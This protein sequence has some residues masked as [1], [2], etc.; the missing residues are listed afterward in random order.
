M[1]D[2]ALLRLLADVNHFLSET[3]A[4]E[5]LSAAAEE[6][7]E[8]LIREIT[9]HLSPPA[10]PMT[11]PPYLDMNGGSRSGG[12][13]VEEYVDSDATG[14]LEETACYE[15]FPSEVDGGGGGGDCGRVSGPLVRWERRFLLGHA[16]RCWASLA[17]GRLLLYPGRGAASAKPSLALCLRGYRARPACSSLVRASRKRDTHFEI[18][19]PGKKTYQ[20]I[21]PSAKEMEQWVTAICL[22]GEQEQSSVSPLSADQELYDD[23]NAKPANNH[24]QEEIYHVISDIS[25]SDSVTVPS[26]KPVP[27]PTCRSPEQNSVYDDVSFRSEE[28]TYYNLVGQG[29]R[30]SGPYEEEIYDD[31][32]NFERVGSVRPSPT[33][34]TSKVESSKASPTKETNSGSQIQQ[35]IQKMEKSF[36]NRKLPLMKQQIFHPV[37]LPSEGDT[38]G[39]LYEPVEHIDNQTT[40]QFAPQLPPRSHSAYT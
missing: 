21:A 37:K 30:D 10:P 26:R 3:L 32:G 35:L 19:C 23:V 20:F 12:M 18:V 6:E 28:S 8:S 17:G 27:L 2:S 39:E 9:T 1:D 7:K 36:S 16:Q 22:A 11:P 40:S 31:I 38:G 34:E 13:A 4:E 25:G 14:A 5:E 29:F 33:K 15:E 24:E